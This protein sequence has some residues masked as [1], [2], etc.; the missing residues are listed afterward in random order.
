MKLEKEKTEKE[1]MS[2]RKA[3]KKVVLINTGA[4]TGRYERNRV[5]TASPVGDRENKPK[6]YGCKA[7]RAG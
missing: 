7:A 4:E 2:G 6:N 5:M 1:R 3:A